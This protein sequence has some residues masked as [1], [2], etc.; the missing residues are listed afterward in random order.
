MPNANHTI[1]WEM[2]KVALSSSGRVYTWGW[3][4]MNQLCRKV[5]GSSPFP[6]CV[7]ALISSADPTQRLY[8]SQISC[9]QDHTLVLTQFGQ[10]YSW[11][12]NN[13]GQLGIGKKCRSAGL[14]PVQHL[15]RTVAFIAA[16]THHSVAM[17]EGGTLYSWGAHQYLGIQSDDKDKFSPVGVGSLAK[18]GVVKMVS[19]GSTFTL[20]LMNSGDVYVWGQGKH[21]QVCSLRERERERV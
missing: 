9:G 8:V 10:V 12:S 13:R 19:V 7:D 20:A 14:S 6:R 3:S 21:G 17:L 11:G 15:R 4:D 1:P 18:I 5:K 2:N 16:G